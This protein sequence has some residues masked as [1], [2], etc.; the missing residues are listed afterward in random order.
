VRQLFFVVP[1]V[2]CP[3]QFVIDAP[4]GRFAPSSGSIFVVDGIKSWI[5]MEL[6]SPIAFI[7]ALAQAPLASK[8]DVGPLSSP[9]L[10]LAGL[11]LIHYANRALISP[12]RTPSRS[13]SHIV[14]PLSAIFFNV[15]NGTLLGSY[16]GSNTASAFLS[17]AFGKPSFWAGTILWLAGFCGNILHDEVLLNIRRNAKA[18]GKAKS[19]DNPNKKQGEHYAVPHGYLYTYISY[20]NYF[21]EWAEWFGFAL[22]AAPIPPMTSLSAVA[23]AIQPPWLFFLS[24]VF[25]MISRAYKG[26]RWY[27]ERFPEYPKERKAVIPFIF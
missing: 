6:V 3:F 21:C 7:Y 14:V 15:V 26:H 16:L 22:A 13:K 17:G 2:V 23:H 19:D 5:I 9:Q 4:F 27:H 10:F 1:P 24:E 18:K 20:P 12:L 11:F 25:L 8:A